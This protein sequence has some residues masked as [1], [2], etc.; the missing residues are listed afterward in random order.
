M[1]LRQNSALKKII[2]IL[3]VIILFSCK[4]KI[5][6]EKNQSLKVLVKSVLRQKVVLPEKMKIYKPFFDYKMSDKEIHDSK[7]V[8]YTEINAS[9]GT[10]V[11]KINEWNKLAKELS[12]YGV[13]VILILRSDDDF[14][15]FKYL[16]ETDKIMKFLY[17]FYLDENEEFSKLNPFMRKN[18]DLK[19]VLVDQTNTI[20]IV[21]NPIYSEGIKELYL[22]QI[23]KRIATE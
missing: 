6:L 10:C 21:G 1:I 12:K 2:F 18:N 23:K 17:P 19:T 8:V 22:S 4:K 16:A 5:N 14:E 15:L 3:C 13:P 7:L 20:L 9:C 11:S